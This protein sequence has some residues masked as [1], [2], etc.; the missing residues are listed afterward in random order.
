MS[1]PVPSFVTQVQRPDNNQSK[2]QTST[3]SPTQTNVNNVS[4]SSD[5]DEDVGCC[6]CLFGSKKRSSPQNNISNN[7]KPQQTVATSNPPVVSK[8]AIPTDRDQIGVNS[9]RGNEPKPNAVK[10]STSKISLLG[11][12]KPGREGRK[13]LVLDLDETLVHSSFQPV[14][15]YDFLIPVEIEGNVYQVCLSLYR[16]LSFYS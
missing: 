9:P 13:C 14:D 16:I 4:R 5:D 2:Q 11:P 1:Q 15:K 7:N 8:I 3:T 6:S 12:Q 10:P